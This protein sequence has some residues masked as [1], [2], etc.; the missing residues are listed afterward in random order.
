MD[1][2]LC[3]VSETAARDVPQFSVEA[4]DRVFLIA[5]GGIGGLATALA[6]AQR[7]FSSHVLEKRTAFSA[8]GAGIQIGPNGGRVLAKLG[9][10]DALHPMAGIPDAVRVHDGRT[11]DVLCRIPLGDH[12]SHRYGAP[13]WVFHRADLHAALLQAVENCPLITLQLTAEVTGIS[14]SADE[15]NA[16]TADGRQLAGAGLI[17]ADGLWSDLRS[18]FFDAR[19]PVFSKRSAARAVLPIEDVP[20]GIVSR[21]VGLWLSEQAHVVHYPVR[22]GNEFA[23]IVVRHDESQTPGWGADVSPTWVREGVRSFAPVLRDLI[24]AVSDWRKWGLYDLPKTQTFAKGRVALLGDAAH[25]ILPFLAQ[26]GVMALEDGWVLAQC[27]AAHKDVDAAFSAYQ[28]ARRQ[29][30]AQVQEASRR[31]G[32]VY[33]MS[34]AL[35]MARNFAL[36][37]APSSMLLAQYDWLYGWCPDNV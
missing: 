8:E 11:G 26:G 31:N 23:L 37:A 6:L 24:S 34:G 1:E 36:K 18:Q 21:D 12:I 19:A 5:G 4:P 13:Y 17:A 15:V 33:H 7:G 16:E 20:S 25:P 22:G 3:G 29:R 9:L 10:S 28:L 27:V 35:A 14:N 32:R 30:V 2:D